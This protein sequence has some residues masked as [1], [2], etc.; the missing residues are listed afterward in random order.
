MG[1]WIASW[2]RGPNHQHCNQVRAAREGVHGMWSLAGRDQNKYDLDMA[3]IE[4]AQLLHINY[5]KVINVARQKQPIQQSPLH[6]SGSPRKR[7]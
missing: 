3:P 2:Y 6:V 5:T 1:A 7:V 4:A